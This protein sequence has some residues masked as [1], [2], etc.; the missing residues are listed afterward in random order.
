MGRL[1]LSCWLL[2]ATGGRD[3][4]Q[5]AEQGDAEHRHEPLRPR[6]S[7]DECRL[8]G[9]LGVTAATH[10]YLSAFRCARRKLV[11][12]GI[13]SAVLP[14][15][16]GVTLPPRKIDHLR[17]LTAKRILLDEMFAMHRACD[18]NNANVRCAHELID[19]ATASV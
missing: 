6:R 4:Q 3:R 18:L 17:H 5:K 19:R 13:A 12:R 1:W 9:S 15:D 2:L 14:D 11:C 7:S 16:T 10:H 8:E